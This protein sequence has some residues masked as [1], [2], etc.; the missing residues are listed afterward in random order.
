M[1]HRPVDHRIAQHSR[2]ESCLAVH[3]QAASSRGERVR[4]APVVRMPKVSISDAIIR[5]PQNRAARN[6]LSGFLLVDLTRFVNW[7]GVGRLSPREADCAMPASMMQMRRRKIRADA[8]AAARCL[9]KSVAFLP[10]AGFQLRGAR[11]RRART[12]E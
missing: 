5:L 12:R 9:P 8:T 4:L 2:A 1:K 3:I 11:L 6:C 7:P 10:Q